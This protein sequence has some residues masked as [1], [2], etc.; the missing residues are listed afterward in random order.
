MVVDWGKFGMTLYYAIKVG[1]SLRILLVYDI[2]KPSII[3]SP[4]IF[5]RNYSHECIV[6]YRKARSNNIASNKDHDDEDAI[7]G[8]ANNF[9]CTQLK[10]FVNQA[11]TPSTIAS[12][13]PASVSHLCP[14]RRA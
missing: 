4:S 3:V 11:H 1:D 14:H 2:S 8:K 6:S 5:E 10:C 13:L 7:K 12:Q 9:S